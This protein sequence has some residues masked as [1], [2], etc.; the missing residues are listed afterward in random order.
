MNSLRAGRAF[1]PAGTQQA[2]RQGCRRHAVA[3]AA[4]PQR[5]AAQAAPTPLDRRTLLLGASALLAGAAVQ[6]SQPAVADEVQEYQTAPNGL[7]WV[8]SVEGSGEAPVKG[9]RIRAHYRGRLQSNGA[10]FDSS[11]E[12]GKPLIFQV[13]VGQVI[14]VSRHGPL[15]GLSCAGGWLCRIHATAAANM[16]APCLHLLLL[17]N[18][19]DTPLQRACLICF[20]H[21]AGTRASLAATACLP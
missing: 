9:A 14:K 18:S 17:P 6:Q 10:V 12:R 11:Y 3:A 1:H 4:L 13:G 15:A 5:Q 21:R 8:D 20:T 7:Q 2:G 19:A 16:S